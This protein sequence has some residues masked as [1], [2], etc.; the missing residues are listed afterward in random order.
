MS[1]QTPAAILALLERHGVRPRK[2]YGQ[3]F[4]ADR[5]LIDKVVKLADVAP[6]DRVVEIG[7]GTGALTVALVERGAR[8]VAY[9]VDEELRPIL[10][11]TLVGRAVD[12]RFADVMEVNL[13]EELEGAPWKM[14][15]NLPYN[16]GTPLLLDVL[17]HVPRIVSMTV[18]V[19]TEV[20]D[21]LIA[22]PG[23]GAYGLPSVI[24]GLAGQP[25]DSFKVPPQ[26]FVPPPQVS[27]TALRIDRRPMPDGAPEA[28]EL[29]RRAFGQRRKMLRRSLGEAVP[30]VAY[31]RA[32]IA[33]SSRPEALAPLDF[34]R[35]AKA[36]AGV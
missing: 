30:E 16:V 29:A 5:N 35:L 36:V 33:P 15:A 1:A 3:H 32:G 9:E 11:E 22:R 8:V 21:R 12:L 24:V 6:D 19:Q 25:V 31:G 27:S 4:L 2:M 34:L 10:A 28:V 23:T 13:E 26:V 20:A 17:L 14:V 7:A 18:M